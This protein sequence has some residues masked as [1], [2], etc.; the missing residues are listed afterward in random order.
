MQSE[1]KLYR[2]VFEEGDE[3]KIMYFRLYM[4]NSVY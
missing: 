3:D 2:A 4:P 1:G